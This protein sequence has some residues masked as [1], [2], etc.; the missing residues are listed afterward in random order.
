MYSLVKTT[1]HLHRVSTLHEYYRIDGNLVLPSC[2]NRKS[3]E[4]KT[5]RKQTTEIVHIKGLN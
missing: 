5:S 2:K 1:L 4:K 3:G